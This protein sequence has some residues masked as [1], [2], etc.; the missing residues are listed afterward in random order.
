MIST[1]ALTAPAAQLD[2]A[3]RTRSAGGD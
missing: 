3:D 2:Y 1:L